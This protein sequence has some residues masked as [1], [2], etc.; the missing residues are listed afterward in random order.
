MLHLKRYIHECQFIPIIF[1]SLHNAPYRTIKKEHSMNESKLDKKHNNNGYIALFIGLILYIAGFAFF[2]EGFER[3]SLFAFGTF[4]MVL[5]IPV[6][7]KK[8]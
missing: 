4:M 5:I 3:T 1:N 8:K 7:N 6:T 2:Q